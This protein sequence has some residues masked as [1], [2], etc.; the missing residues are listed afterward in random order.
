MAVYNGE[1]CLA[2]T[3]ESILNQ[4]F[5]SFEFLIVNDCSTDGTLDVNVATA[6]N[7]HIC[8]R[9]GDISDQEIMCMFP[10]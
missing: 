4:T 2:T 6:A 5:T 3:I 9:A 10:L 1:T 8:A 7:T